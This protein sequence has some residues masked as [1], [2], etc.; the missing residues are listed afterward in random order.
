MI[1]FPKVDVLKTAIVQTIDVTLRETQIHCA[2]YV[3]RKENTITYDIARPKQVCTMTRY[4]DN[5][6]IFF[7]VDTKNLAT[8]KQGAS[9]RNRLQ[10]ILK[11]AAKVAWRRKEQRENRL[12]ILF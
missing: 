7:C 2:E 11:Q 8:F 4:E 12:D 3:S 10:A 5:L 6:N 1:F 9:P